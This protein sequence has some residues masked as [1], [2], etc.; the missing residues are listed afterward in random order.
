MT[1][2]GCIVGGAALVVAGGVVAMDKM[3]KEI[4]KMAP[5]LT[6]GVAGAACKYTKDSL[7]PLLVYTVGG[8]IGNRRHFM[9]PFFERC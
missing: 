6:G 9:T 1:L 4:P 3:K 7:V 5:M 8:N 2:L